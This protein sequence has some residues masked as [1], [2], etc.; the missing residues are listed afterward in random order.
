MDAQYKHQ[1]HEAKLY[2]TW[3]D[4]GV[5]TPDHNSKSVDRS[6]FCII[7]PPPNANDPLHVGHAMFLAIEDLFTR[8]YRM[9]GYDTLWLPGVDHAGIE[10]Q[11]VFEKKLQ[12]EGKSRFDFDRNSLYQHIYAYV[13]ENSGVAVEQMRKIGASADWSRFRFTLD[14]EVVA[15]ITNTFISMEQK[16]LIYRD[17]QL[18]NYCTK[19]GTSYSELEVDQKDQTSPLYYLQYGP[20]V[21]ATTR[22]ETT[23]GDEA[24]AVHPKDKRYNKLVGQ[25]I[26]I[27][28]AFG[29][30]HLP[31]VA[32]EFVDPDF[33]TGAVKITPAHDHNDFLV[34]KRHSLPITQVIGFNGKLLENTG[35]F[36]HQS[37]ANAR[38]A[39]VEE[40]ERRGLLVKTDTA[41]SNSVGVCYRCG[42][43]IEPLPL[44]QF[45]VAVQHQNNNLV[46]HALKFLK[47]DQT[48][49]HGAG[50]KKILEHWLRNLRDWNISRQ[51]VWGIPIPVWYNVADHQQYVTATFVDISG[52]RVTD[53]I[54]ALLKTYAVE[55][56]RNGL[57]SLRADVGV[58]F[59][60][61]SGL[62]TQKGVWL[63]ETDT[64]DTWFSSSQ[65]PVVTLKS[66]DSSD[67]ARFYPTSIMETGYDILP[68]WV[69]RMML[70]CGYLTNQT[71]FS[72]VYLHGLIRDHRGQKMSK[73]KGNVVNPIEVVANYGAD[74]LR[75]ALVIRSTPGQDKNV[76]EQDFRA[77]RNFTNKIWNAAR[78]V[79][80][81]HQSQTTHAPTTTPAKPHSEQTN[82]FQLR[83]E[84]LVQETTSQLEHRQ[85]GLAADR[86]YDAFW[87]WYCD[88]CL[89][90]HKAQKL[91]LED[92]T[93][94]LLVFLKLLHPFT[95][96]VTEA[97]WQEL[98]ARGLTS[99]PMLV[100]ATWPNNSL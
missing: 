64:L 31:V 10:T 17:L 23:F 86:L 63:P 71:P 14:K 46:K 89:E 67:F 3:L 79:V 22:P 98:F 52:K 83:L 1:A 84:K 85:I 95:P 32:D 53:T 88:E 35:E 72:E 66:G 77:M 25:T 68:F 39:V 36:A 87:H 62:P 15:Q 76:G 81:K 78:Y 21:V 18:V 27:E 92:V 75:M 4:S 42:R 40:L 56:I 73:S 43:A 8:F 41:Y 38:K 2:Q 100:S 59:V 70:M 19:C 29:T 6:T 74:A 20:L 54:E 94:G 37:I 45:F 58:P 80:L 16:G 91:S 5:F 61:S 44:P 90:L 33:G 12:K 51:I 96:F 65:W 48:I 26:E 50:R 13:Q 69:M 11:F 60:T 82:Q 7:M 9:K 47:T 24:V 97:V 30:K 55:E 49:I 93:R 57:Q 99:E 28:G 34:G